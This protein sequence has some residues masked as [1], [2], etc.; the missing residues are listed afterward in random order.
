MKRLIS[1]FMAI[2]VFALISAPAVGASGDNSGTEYFEDGSYLVEGIGDIDEESAESAESFLAKIVT[3]IKR[4]I[5]LLF[6]K[7]AQTVTQTKYV[8]YYDKNGA[9]LWAVYLRG[10]F[11]YDGKTASCTDASVT[12]Y[13]Y[14]ADWR[15]LSCNTKK[16]GST[17]SADFTVRQYKLGVALKTVERRLV[18]TCDKD[19]NVK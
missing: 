10:T 16:S 11:T 4:I 6:K 12:D 5:S 9:L 14:D 15:L 1:V 13:M 17:A 19:G 2:L 3:F 8:R 18:L 7:E